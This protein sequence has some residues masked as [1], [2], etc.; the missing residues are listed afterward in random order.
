[1]T[2]RMQDAE[3][4]RGRRGRRRR[5]DEEAGTADLTVTLD[6]GGR[7]H[8]ERDDGEWLLVVDGTPQSSVHP[9]DP[10][11]LRFG[12]IRQMG[13]VIDLAFPEHAPLTALHLGAGALSIPRYV[14]ATRPGSRQQ[15]IEL[16]PK[17]VELV[18]RVAPL[19]SRS[20]I[21]LRYGD[22]RGE[23]AKLPEGL[24]GTVELAV[25]DVFA[26]PRTPA[27]VTSV[28]F[29][30]ALG[31][32]L[33]PEAVVLVNLADGRGLAFA[34]GVTATLRAA[35]GEVRLI[36][37]PSVFKGRRFGNLVAVAS[38]ERLE[39]GGLERRAA[40]AFPPARVLDPDE[41][42]VWTGTARPVF[43]ADAVP[44]PLPGKA[45]FATRE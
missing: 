11:S 20:G 36:A 40:S 25:V 21:R 14:D 26:G 27:H 5:A 34:R 31:A 8:L 17:L 2:C 12:Y 1:M 32:W 13:H 43:D 9:D 22:A 4:T 16:E 23:L 35:F 3:D 7:A 18:R 6:S 33:A 44:S 41:T 45:V 28:E 42:R 19:P 39:L 24:R 37:D 38:S 15:V 10:R 30:A 29:F